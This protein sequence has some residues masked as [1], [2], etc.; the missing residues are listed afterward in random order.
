MVIV[1]AMIAGF[2]M[3]MVVI[4]AQGQS[5]ILSSAGVKSER[6]T[7][8]AAANA[9]DGAINALRGTAAKG[10]YGLSCPQFQG[11]TGNVVVDCS[12]LP[13]S[14]AQQPAS[15]TAPSYTL[16]TTRGLSGYGTG[17]GIST[18]G[19]NNPLLANGPV[20][21]N[22]TINAPKGLKSTSSVYAYGACTGSPLVANPLQ[23]NRGI[24]SN[25]PGGDATTDAS[26]GPWAAV[27]QGA[28]TVTPTLTCNTTTSVATMQP[29]AYYDLSALTT[30]IGSCAITYL[31]PGAY[32]FDFDATSSSNT[33][34]TINNTTV[35]GTPKDWNPTTAGST[36]SVPGA[37]YVDDASQ[38]AGVQLMFARSSRIR[39]GGSGS[40]EL[41]PTVSSTAQ[42]IVVYGR[43]TSQSAGLPPTFTPTG[44]TNASPATMGTPLTNVLT[45]DGVVNNPPDG[46]L[47]SGK[48]AT[49][50][51]KLTGFGTSAIPAGSVITSV[52]V[53]VAHSELGGIATFGIT[54]TAGSTNLCTNLDT[55]WV[56]SSS[57][58]TDTLTCA[59]NITWTTPADAQVTYQLQRGNNNA[60]TKEFLDGIQ[61]VVTTVLNPLRA[62]TLGTTVIDVSPGGGNKGVMYLWGT[63]YTPFGV[64]NADFKN[65]NQ[66][67]FA[68]GAIVNG[69][70]GTNVPPAQK[71]PP[72]ALP[73]APATYADRVVDLTAKV[74]GKQVL[75]SRVRFQDSGGATPGNV[76]D[77]LSWIA[78]NP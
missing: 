77:V 58:K 50:T 74:N 46:A 19:G 64:V 33:L 37:C 2:G 55:G 42:E 9:T 32:Y 38:P 16:L 36:P 40:L 63:V 14:G 52:Q 22:S 73:V 26:T 12:P 59:P 43:K 56:T 34:W 20:Y 53:I 48:N 11:S 15:S 60:S 21:S 13:G 41:C 67:G 54:A 8:Y 3:L 66:T 69:F 7:E 30:G 45:I 65:Q 51:I 6:A 61:L 78:V 31:S 44:A 57:L 28:P 17:A 18:S 24:F 23:C 71:L 47:L 29:G 10:R 76:I 4:G 75:K 5:G 49:G 70:A 62:Q 1:L 35:G 68:R 27:L 25:D 39:V 72:F